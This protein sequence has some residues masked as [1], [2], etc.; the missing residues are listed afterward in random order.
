MAR[1]SGDARYALADNKLTVRPRGGTPEK[2]YL[3]AAGIEQALSRT[4][5]LPV[6]PEWRDVI[7]RAAAAPMSETGAS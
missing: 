5:G 6:A 7:G 4:F 1:T 3:D 2:R